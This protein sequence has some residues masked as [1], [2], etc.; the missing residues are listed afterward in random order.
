M[1]NDIA[2]SD[3][4]SFAMVPVTG[5]DEAA[6]VFR[7]CL[8]Q[9]TAEEEQKYGAHLRRGDFFDQLDCQKVGT[10]VKIMP[11][12]GWTTW[13]RWEQGQRAP[14]YS[15]RNRAEVPKSDLEWRTDG[16]KRTP[17]VARE[18]VRLLVAVE[19]KPWPY[20]FV[21]KSTGLAAF[22]KTIGALETR[23]RAEKKA[24][25]GMYELTTT[26]DKN[27]NNQPFK[28]LQ[29]RPVGEPDAGMIEVGRAVL[30]RMSE[31]TAKADEAEGDNPG[32]EIPI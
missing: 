7:L 2:K 12:T 15:T 11:I 26:D 1:S 24:T 32:D 13:E 25:P 31:F 6:Q 10:S 21:F 27:A 18:S 16:T 19:G 5:Q 28:R 29:A 23:R 20:L 8:Y 4:Q 22:Q 3:G 9:G 14:V 30:A 17:P